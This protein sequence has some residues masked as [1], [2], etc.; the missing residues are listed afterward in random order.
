VI[1]Y[2]QVLAAVLEINGKISVLTQRDYSG[3]FDPASLHGVLSKGN[4]K[5]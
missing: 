1:N 4:F 2:D 3:D 5:D